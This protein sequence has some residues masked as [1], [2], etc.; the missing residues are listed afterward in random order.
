VRTIIRVRGTGCS[1]R[2]STAAMPERPSSGRSMRLGLDQAEGRVLTSR[3][4]GFPSRQVVGSVIDGRRS[5]LRP[6]AGGANDVLSKEG[7]LAGRPR[8]R[9]R[10]APLRAKPRAPHTNTFILKKK[11]KNK[12]KTKIKKNKKKERLAVTATTPRSWPVGRRSQASCV[13]AVGPDA[14]LLT[15]A[16]LSADI[17]WAE[18]VAHRRK[19]PRPVS[20]GGGMRQSGPMLARRNNRRTRR[21][22]RSMSMW[23]NIRCVWL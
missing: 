8:V 9:R 10:L 18:R 5:F 7:V 13:H 3:A 11:Q 19:A 12:K 22:Q 4:V 20:S 16:A 15:P 21:V 2:H 1:S 14:R 23:R 17:C 6:G